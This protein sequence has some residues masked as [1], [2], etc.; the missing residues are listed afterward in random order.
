M[1][2][3]LVGEG[4]EHVVGQQLLAAE[5]GADYQHDE[6]EHDPAG[7]GMAGSDVGSM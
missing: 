5:D 1:G 2:P 6:K 7:V 3:P 4:G